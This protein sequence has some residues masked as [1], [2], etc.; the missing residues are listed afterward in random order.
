MFNDMTA[1]NNKPKQIGG[2]P[3]TSIIRSFKSKNG[4]AFDATLK[5]DEEFRF[6]FGEKK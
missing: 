3:K 5:F 2:K 1:E 6:E 4:K